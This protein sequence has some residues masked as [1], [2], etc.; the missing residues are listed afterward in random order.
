VGQEAAISGHLATLSFRNNKKIL[1]DEQA[2]KYH[3]A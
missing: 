3:F 2:R 1:W